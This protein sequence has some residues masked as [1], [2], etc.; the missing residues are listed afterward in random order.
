MRLLWRFERQ[1][2]GENEC[3]PDVFLFQQAAGM[4]AAKSRDFETGDSFHGGVVVS[5]GTRSLAAFEPPRY[6]HIEEIRRFAAI[7]NSA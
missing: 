5:G 7:V 6:I 3:A 1:W 2:R 4:R